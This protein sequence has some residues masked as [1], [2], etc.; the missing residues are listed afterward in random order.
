MRGECDQKTQTNL[1]WSYTRNSTLR[2]KEKNDSH[3]NVFH[4]LEL[5]YRIK[6]SH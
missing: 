4:P 2:I 1:T 3:L 6:M 5:A